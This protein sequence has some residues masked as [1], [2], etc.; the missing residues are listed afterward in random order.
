MPTLSVS[1]VYGGVGGR[2][3]GVSW[4]GIR[5]SSAVVEWL[6]CACNV[7]QDGLCTAKPLHC[8]SYGCPSG[9]IANFCKIV[10]G[11]IDT[12]DGV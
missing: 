4:Y 11:N 3:E 8:D 2:E 7:A 6:Q 12:A 1:P 9:R 10:L 5:M